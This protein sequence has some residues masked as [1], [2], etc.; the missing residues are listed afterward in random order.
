MLKILRLKTSLGI[1]IGA[2]AFPLFSLQA[3]PPVPPA[4]P[5]SQAT[6]NLTTEIPIA[7][8]LPARDW[9]KN[10]PVSDSDTIRYE[11]ET[12]VPIHNRFE[13][14]ERLAMGEYSE[15]EIETEALMIVLAESCKSI[16]TKIK[17]LKAVLSAID[18]SEHSDVTKTLLKSKTQALFSSVLPD[19]QPPKNPDTSPLR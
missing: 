7:P 11:I 19:T 18:K 16:K 9:E 13:T 6:Y 3:Y 5:S 17:L 15:T 2:M 1:A 4:P 12:N 14:Q 10:P 8:K